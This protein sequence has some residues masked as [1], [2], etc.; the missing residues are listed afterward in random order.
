MTEQNNKNQA[1]AAAAEDENHIIAERRAKLARLR[2]AGVAY[3]NDFVRKDL[4]GDLRAKFGDKSR[5]ELEELKPEVAVSGRM[6]LKRVMGKAAFA[7]MHDFTGDMQYFITPSEVGD[8]A[9]AQFKAMDL[10]DIVAAQGRLFRTNRGELS[11]HVTKIRL[12]TKSIRPLPNKFKG[13]QDPEQCCRQRYADLIINPESR[14][15]FETRSKVVASIRE[16]MQ[17]HRFMEVETPMLNP[18]PGG[19]NAKPFVTHH[20]ALDMDLF[21][22]IAPELYLKRLVVG[23]VER[24]FEINRCFRNEGIDTR[25][26][27]EFT[28]IEFYATYWTYR[29]QMEFTEN[30]L[31]TVAQKA[32]G[33]M[34]LNYQGT[35]IDLSKP[36]ARLTPEQAIMKYAPQYTPENLTD[37]AFL[38]AELKRLGEPQ[39]DW[40]GMGALVMGLFE[41]VAE[42]KLIEPTF[43]I[44][45]PVE[46][47]PLAR[48]SD[49]HPELTER[50][51]LFIY[52]RETANGFSELND[53]E[54]QA[55]RFQAQADAKTHGDDEAMYYDAD[56]IRA[57]EYG[58]PPTA[59]CGIGIDRFVML[60]TNASTIRDVLLFPTLRLEA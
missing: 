45:Y 20:N 41:A 55:R 30:L 42:S 49:T 1:P 56:F 48:A 8:E 40:V 60:L 54:D 59:G 12:L 21:L 27:P 37:E 29:D 26:N 39:P 50:F 10:G 25:H 23:G 52:G 3:P 35:E 51:E 15:R 22:R 44:D 17:A 34:V 24:V 7:T 31:R 32:T 16:Y 38:R 47:S 28:T 18:I 36:F 53:P 6:M 2:E 4:F 11:V 19:A 5:E 9:F 33:S 13:L 43:I 58:L 57:L 46:I 14:T